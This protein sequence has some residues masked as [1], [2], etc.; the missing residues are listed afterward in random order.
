MGL[1]MEDKPS[2]IAKPHPAISSQELIRLLFEVEELISIVARGEYGPKDLAK[3]VDL[4]KVS[5]AK[6]SITERRLSELSAVTVAVIRNTS[7]GGR[8]KLHNFMGL[9][10]GLRGAFV[11]ELCKRGSVVQSNGIEEA[12]MLKILQFTNQGALDKLIV[13]L[14]EFLSDLRGR[15]DPDTYVSVE[16]KETL[17]ELLENVLAQL[18]SPL[19]EARTLSILKSRLKKFSKSVGEKLEGRASDHASNLIVKILTDVF[20]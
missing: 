10:H 18:K 12:L 4:I 7:G 17:I 14:D 2:E 15:N 9:S 8:P 6:A 5:L 20:G 3:L 16:T 11:E 1:G 19:V 13:Q